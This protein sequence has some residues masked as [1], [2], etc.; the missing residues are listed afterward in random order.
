[1]QISGHL[2]NQKQREPPLCKGRSNILLMC[3]FG[4]VL[5]FRPTCRC[6][7]QQQETK[8]RKQKS[9]QTNKHKHTP[10]ILTYP[11]PTHTPTLYTTIGNG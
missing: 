6:E 3:E 2:I 8:T 9:K 5:S 4:Y 1:M 10:H 11:T 7:K